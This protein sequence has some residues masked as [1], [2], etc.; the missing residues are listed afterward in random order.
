MV[1]LILPVT[2]SVHMCES[3]VLVSA[4]WLYVKVIYLFPF[5]LDSIIIKI[6]HPKSLEFVK[7]C[8]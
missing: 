4:D 1:G 8:T 3:L 2:Y 6:Y 7:L 5:I